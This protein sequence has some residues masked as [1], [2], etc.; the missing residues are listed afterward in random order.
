[1]ATGSA[2]PLPRTKQCSL[3]LR[4]S[5]IFLHLSCVFNA[6]PTVMG[7]LISASFTL[8]AS[9]LNGL[10]RA[11]SRHSLNHNAINARTVTCVVNALVLATAFS[12]PALQYTPNFVVLA[13]SDP[14]ELTTLSVIMFLPSALS[15]TRATSLVSPDWETTINPVLLTSCIHGKSFVSVSA[16]SMEVTLS[17]EPNCFISRS[18]YLA[19]FNEVPQALKT[20]CLIIFIRSSFVSRPDNITFS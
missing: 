11:R 10:P 8:D 17:N 7:S 2:K 3:S 20:M 16:A 13:M 12:R 6:I 5:A 14:T 4:R 18:P 1:M 9:T 19:A 15:T